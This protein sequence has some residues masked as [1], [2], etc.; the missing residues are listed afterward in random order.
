MGC[1][2]IGYYVLHKGQKVGLVMFNK[3]WFDERRAMDE[4]ELDYVIIKLKKKSSRPKDEK[5]S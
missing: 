1:C 3:Q 4:L 2:K 5:K